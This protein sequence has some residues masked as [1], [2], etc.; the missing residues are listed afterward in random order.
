MEKKKTI[1]FGFRGWML[2][3][4]QAIAFMTYCAFTNY[5][6]NILSQS[7]FY[8]QSSQMS[9]YYLIGSIA[10]IVVQFILSKIVGKIKSIKKVSVGFGIASIALAILINVVSPASTTI[11]LILFG[12]L[13]FSTQ[14]YATYA[15][16]I[17]C[18]QWFPRRKGT[19]MGVA[20]IA[21]PL[22]MAVIGYCFAEP[23]FGRFGA[24]MGTEMGAKVEALIASGIDPSKAES[25]AGASIAQS[26][27]FLTF[28]PFLIIAAVG[29]LIG[30]IFIKDYPEQCGAYRDNDKS[31]TPEIANRMMLEEIENRKTTVWTPLK[32]MACR[33]FWFGI[34]SV[35]LLLAFSVGIATQTNAMITQFP[36]LNYNMVMIGFAVCGIFGS[37]LLGI[38]DT[39]FGTK[40][41]IMLTCILAIVSGI[42][43]IMNKAP[44]LVV[45]MCLLGMFNGATSNFSVSICA[46]Y[47]RRED[48]PSVFTTLN[49]FGNLFNSF[50]PIIVA[51]L[52]FM[53]GAPTNT[54]VY[55]A[56]TAF[57]VIALIMILLFSPKHI[58][59]V[60]DKYREAAGKPLDD[61]LVGRK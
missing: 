59:A 15:I 9:T 40:L 28:I 45:S 29:L 48:F 24:R 1:N 17:L 54:Y 13:T 14:M 32:T 58:K 35:G 4:Y 7:G 36:E 33:D 27:A 46:Q 43:G 11:W 50:G 57:G 22:T 44:M 56:C 21:F 2:I 53:K 5:P 30:I 26:S 39:R 37:W 55:L 18:G 8:P 23:F 16:G 12:L 61:E 52:I 38:I 20:T 10:C 47:W 49:P 60:D 51:N 41:A 6:M 42:F 19:V 31:I 34:I 25:M 3:L